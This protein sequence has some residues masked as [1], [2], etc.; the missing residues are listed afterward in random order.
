MTHGEIV[1]CSKDIGDSMLVYKHITSSSLRWKESRW[2]CRVSKTNTSQKI[3]ELQLSINQ[4]FMASVHMHSKETKTK[5]EEMEW[6]VNIQ[7]E[8]IDRLT[9]E[10][11]CLMQR[12]P[13][14]V[15]NPYK[16]IASIKT[17][18]ISVKFIVSSVLYTRTFLKWFSL[19]KN[20]LNQLKIESN[21]LVSV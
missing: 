8:Q 14:V 17:L 15:G 13:K 5:M 9:Y 21:Y 12:N 19:E 6:R 1:V 7:N 18:I 4:Q 11:I 2:R 3:E 20:C 10:Y 16:Q